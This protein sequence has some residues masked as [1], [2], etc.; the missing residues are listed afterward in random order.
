MTLMDKIREY[1]E[2]NRPF[3]LQLSDTRILEI[4]GRDWISA[5]PSR[6]VTSV[7]IGENGQ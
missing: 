7:S 5:H 3:R 6:A 1:A 2:S 4:K